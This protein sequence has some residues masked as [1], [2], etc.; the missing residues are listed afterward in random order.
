M[1]RVFLSYLAA[2]LATI[3][4]TTVLPFSTVAFAADA[5]TSTQVKTATTMYITKTCYSYKTKSTKSEKIKKLLK[6]AAIKVIGEAKSYY[7]L[8]D[9]SYVLKA[10]V[11][12]KRVN[13][14]NSN[15]KKPII[16]YVLKDNAKTRSSAL[17]NGKVVDT[18]EKGTKLLVVAK[19]NSGF[20]KL[21]DGSYIKASSVTKNK[22][23]SC[24][25]IG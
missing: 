19:T 12:A 18:L 1:K 20:F 7:E 23:I 21:D 9:G 13:W 5:S 4:M 3:M 16:R 25:C 22:Q 6:G 17:A 2:V 10:N 8:E 14:T 24:H 11:G 15:Y